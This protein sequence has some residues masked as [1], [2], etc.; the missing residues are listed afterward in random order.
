MCETIVTAIA[1][2]QDELR[3]VEKQLVQLQ[4]S[5]DQL[6]GRAAQ[7]AQFIWLGRQLLG[8]EAPPDLV[9]LPAVSAPA[10]PQSKPLSA[11]DYAQQVLAEVAHPMR[12]RDILDSLHQRGHMRDK[13]AGQVLG[14]AIRKHPE[15][16]ECVAKG[17][18]A[19][20]GWSP[21][22]KELHDPGHRLHAR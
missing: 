8:D 1:A 15:R 4:A 18:Y 20:R 6:Q 14:N 7:L 21:A 3:E 9:A 13:W 2:A 17:V 10:R 11:A 12:V 16:F 5:L 22:R 19:L